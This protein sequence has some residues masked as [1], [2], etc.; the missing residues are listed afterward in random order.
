M[1]RNTKSL[2][3]KQLKQKLENFGESG[4]SNVKFDPDD[5]FVNKYMDLDLTDTVV[6]VVFI[7][8]EFEDELLRKVIQNAIKQ[9]FSI[10]ESNVQIQTPN[11]TRQISEEYE[12]YIKF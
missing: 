10:E 1:D 11:S 6:K 3:Q 5:H 12:Y 9:C 4:D 2:A 7:G 8:Q